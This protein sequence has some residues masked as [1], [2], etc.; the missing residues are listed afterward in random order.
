MRARIGSTFQS[1]RVRNYRLFAT[2]QL[3]SLIFGWVQITAQDWLV[4]QV[5]HNS[6]TALGVV[7]AF[8]FAPILLLSLY[9]GKLADR[10]D[11]RTLLLVANALYLVL[12]GGMG[13]IVTLGHVRLG[14]VFAF[15]LLWGAVSAVEQPVR[16]AFVS[17]LV[18]NE[19]LP[20]ALALSAATFN[21]ARILGPAL[22]GV[23]IATLGTGPA[24]VLNAVSYAGPLIVLGLM[25]VVEFNRDSSR[26]RR[27]AAE[28]RVRDGLR[29]VA[30]RPDLVLPMAL[31][32]VI[33]SLAFNFNL[34][35]P[36]LARAVFHQGAASFGLLSTSL[37]VG[38]L[39]GA[40]A[41]SGRRARPSV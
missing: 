1:L 30:R 9:A 41:G 33:S 7:T 19:L 22:G 4:L 40:L 37:A 38:A 29:Y 14:Y 28:A 13:A 32:L 36:L 27:T 26:V 16:Q 31:M 21:S 23:A 2:G 6:G 3:I 25:R 8:Q 34:T 18:P 5:S 35:M 10:F 17:E 15:A 11:K 12:A 24:F 20:N 39:V